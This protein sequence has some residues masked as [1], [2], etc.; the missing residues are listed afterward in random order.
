MTK[1]RLAFDICRCYG[2]REERIC[3][4]RDNCARY[5]DRNHVG[6]RTPFA[7][8]LCDRGE[9]NYIPVDESLKK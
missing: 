2:E 3:H 5:I 9:D 7:R 1:H 6:E 8:L 4:V